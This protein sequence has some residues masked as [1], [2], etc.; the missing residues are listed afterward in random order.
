MRIEQTR[1]L[2]AAGILPSPAPTQDVEALR[3]RLEAL[4]L[5]F[6]AEALSDLLTDAVKQNQNAAAFLDALLRYE[7]ER[8]NERRIGQ[9]LKISHLPTGQTLANFDFAFQPSLSQNKLETLSTCSWIGEC[10][11]LLLAGPPGVGKTHLAI[12]LGVRAIECGFSVCFSRVDELLHQLKKDEEISPAR[13]KHKKYMA[14]NLLIVD[15]MGFQAFSRE[16][17]NL[18]FRVINYRYQRGATCITTNKGIADWPEML[19]GDE[20][21]AGAI[22]DRLLHAS[23]VVNIK[24]RSYRLRELEAELTKRQMTS[25]A[26]IDSEEMAET[27]SP[28]A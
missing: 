8:Q 19:A 20:V 21:L 10:Q 11:T 12:A 23:H 15:E 4:R 13:L 22:L 2:L 6:A 26:G 1:K 28:P 16:E 17:A 14:A 7:L 3:K 27:R 24:G 25:P 18:F 5:T 9:A